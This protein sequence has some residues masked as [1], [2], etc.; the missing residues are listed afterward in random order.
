[1]IWP[2]TQ[3]V[4][5]AV[6]QPGQDVDADL[7]EGGRV[8]GAPSSVGEQVDPL[9]RGLGLRGGQSA[10]AE[11][12][13]AVLVEPG[14]HRAVAQR[15]VV[16]ALV[17]PGI[18][19][20]HEA[21]QPDDEL[22]GRP[23]AGQLAA[24]PRRP[25]RSAPAASPAEMVG[26]HTH[27]G[28]VDVAREERRVHLREGRARAARRGRTPGRPRAG[29][30]PGRRGPR[31]RRSGTGWSSR[32]TASSSKVGLARPISAMTPSNR[33]ASWLACRDRGAIRAP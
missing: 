2:R 24:G 13:G 19:R 3:V 16:A 15:L 8:P 17:V 26:E 32:S 23:T 6:E 18:D 27:L 31:R 1:M 22:T 25:S 10:G 29:T 30:R 4:Q 20:C 12:G 33:A 5:G 28:P 11:H 7:V 14:A 21:A 9:D